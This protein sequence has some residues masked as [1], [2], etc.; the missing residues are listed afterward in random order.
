MLHYI[1]I[2]NMLIYNSTIWLLLV[3]SLKMK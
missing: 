3:T 2:F 1:L